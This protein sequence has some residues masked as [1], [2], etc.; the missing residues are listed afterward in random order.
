[1]MTSQFL[2]FADSSKTH[3]F[4]Y[5]ENEILFFPEMKKLIH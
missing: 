3:K 5:F 2:N 1:M 4:K